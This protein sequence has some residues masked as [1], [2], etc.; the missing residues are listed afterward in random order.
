MKSNGRLP[1]ESSS[2]KG[3]SSSG[4][5][6]EPKANGNKATIKSLVGVAALRKG[7]LLGT[8]ELCERLGIS[9]YQIRLFV[10]QGR[11]TCHKFNKRNWKYDYDKVAREL[12]FPGN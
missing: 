9:P 1:A 7:P 12:G 4:A 5:S 8:A 3:S 10:K 6:G 2:P 11:I